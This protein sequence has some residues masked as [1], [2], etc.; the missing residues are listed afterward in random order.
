M[1]LRPCVAPI[2]VAV[3]PLLK[4]KPELVAKAKE[5]QHLLQP[6]MNVFYD[7]AA[8]IG[9]RYRRQDEVGTPFCVAIDFETLGE[10][11]ASMKDT[12]TIRHRDSMEQERVAISDLLSWL[13]ERIR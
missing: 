8:A 3:L 13:L 12:V 10:E 1:R 5:V 9:R 6:F 4:N 11:D 7:E 2:K